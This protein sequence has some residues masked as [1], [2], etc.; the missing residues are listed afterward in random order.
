MKFDQRAKFHR[1]QTLFKRRDAA[2]MLDK[3]HT[4]TDTAIRKMEFKHERRTPQ[5]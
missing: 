3:E 1:L 2:A 4:F 5:R